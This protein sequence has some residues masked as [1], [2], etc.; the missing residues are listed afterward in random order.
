MKRGK[1]DEKIVGPM[2]PRLHVN[3][4][5][6]KGG[7][8]AP[9]RNKMALYEQL[10][11]PSQRFNHGV[12]LHN[13]ETS[14]NT[15]PPASSSQGIGPERNHGFP[16]HL[17]SLIPTR[18][19]E[20]YTF[21]SDGANLNASLVQF[22]KRKKV[23]EDDLRVPVYIHSRT[24]QSN[25]KN[26][27]SFDRKKLT[28][29][30]KG[31]RYIDCSTAG[32]NDFER[33][34][35]SFGSLLVNMRKDVI[36]ETK[37]LLQVSPSKEQSIK[38]VRDISSTGEN[39]DTLVRQAKVAPNQVCRDFPVSK[40]NILCQGDDTFL[41][42]ACDYGSQFNDT[43]QGDGLVE[44]T[45]ETDKGNAPVANQT[46][47]TKAINDTEYHVTRNCNTIQKG[48]LNKTVNICKISKLDSVS[49]PKVSPDD[50]VEIIGQK[51][52]WKAR[53]AI[54]SQQRLFAV[55]VFELHR[56]IKVQKLIA[57]SPDLLLEHAAF[58]GKSPL[59]GPTPK[60]L[61]ME[62]GVKP[63]PQTLKRKH[64]SEKANSKMEC[65]AE[66]AVGKTCLSSMKNGS[67]HSNYTPFSR[68]QHSANVS[69]DSGMPPWCFQ[70]SPGHQWLIPIM[71]PSEGLVYKPYP[72]P[73][74]TGTS[75]E[76][77]YGPTP[78]GGTFMNAA[79]VIPASHQGNGVPQNTPPGSH[80]Y[81]HPCGMPVV[82]AAM[83]ESAVEQ[84][85]QFS[86]H[87]SRGQNGQETD[88]YTNNQSSCDLPVQRNRAISHVMK[89]Q[90]FKEVELQGSTASS[91]SEMAKGISTGQIAEG[92]DA[93]PLFPMAPVAAPEGVPLSLETGQQPRVIKVVP[94]NPRS[95]TESAARIFQSIQDERKQ[96][97]LV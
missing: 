29:A 18:R 59:K 41:Q 67:H 86:E 36:S 52:F 81:F 68:N 5:E 25:N 80:A 4:K 20:K 97:D 62:F 88:I 85:K 34:P 33:D 79:Y 82:N 39:V 6:D 46:S 10:S 53:K 3:D 17:P 55:Q 1:D 44:S 27:E 65:S 40:H 58:L 54:A 71:T 38:S 63:Q 69:A 95:A 66:N 49:T 77:G 72:G 89:Y 16:A 28:L 91:P 26:L 9:P 8:R 22:Q 75:C 76:G 32:Q 7:P 12:L 51:R 13:P 84:V 92:R 96:Y 43:R 78:L 37:G 94:H 19:A 14:S 73:R 11:I 70:Q 2:F 45:R 15:I 74:F 24:G 87:A 23:D 30:P 83:S 61:T 50:V 64:E 21:R 60:K 48:N 42:R 57:G 31:S 90:T 35:K 93:L 56:L 47:P